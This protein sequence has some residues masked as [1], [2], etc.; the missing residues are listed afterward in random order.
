MQIREIT[1]QLNE[2]ALGALATGFSQATGINMPKLGTDAAPTPYKYGPAGQQQAAKMSEPVI[3]QQ[4]ER[5]LANWNASI[6]NLLKQNGVSSPAQLD[7]STKQS[8]AK[9]L[10]NQLHKNFMQN[11]TGADY[12]TLPRLV[13]IAKQPEAQDAVKQIQTA[14]NSILNFNAPAQDKQQQLAQWLALSRAA[15][16]A[17]SLVQFHP[18]KQTMKQTAVPDLKQNPDGS[19][20]IGGQKLNPQDPVDAK[21]IQRINAQRTPT[22][23]A[24]GT[25]T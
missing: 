16:N 2:D 17:M 15:Y 1:Q 25:T 18:S 8:L 5:E 23:G 7:R 20:S 3:Q 24:T 13:D 14:L 9:T 22:S 19:Y 21:I 11:K 6:L 10:V 12:K 4:A